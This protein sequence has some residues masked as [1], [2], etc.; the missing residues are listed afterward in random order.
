MDNFEAKAIKPYLRFIIGDVV[1]LKSD[2]KRK[3]PMTVTR[4]VLFEDES[5]YNL[6]WTT[7]QSTID[8][9]IFAD[10]ALTK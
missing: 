5:D 2:M 6:R 10:E 7:S 9:D 8:S 3:T 4:Y 1:Y